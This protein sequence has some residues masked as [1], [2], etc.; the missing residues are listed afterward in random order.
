MKQEAHSHMYTSAHMMV[1]T[2][3]FAYRR[4][5]GSEGQR[6]SF[7][8][9]ADATATSRVK[10][11]YNSCVMKGSPPQRHTGQASLFRLHCHHVTTEDY[12]N[13][14][15]R[16]QYVWFLIHNVYASFC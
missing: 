7:T 1:Q 9:T 2:C 4:G 5:R 8:P 15:A 12:D 3:V 13:I 14:F 6:C 16:L 10:K 11:S